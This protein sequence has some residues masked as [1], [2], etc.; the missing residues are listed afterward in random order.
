M[1]EKVIKKQGE[2]ERF[3]K[4]KITVSAVKAGAPL[5]KAR[6]IAD[7]VEKEIEGKIESKVLREKILDKLEAE[8]PEWRKNWETYDKAVKKI[9]NR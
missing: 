2:E 1:V 8:N 3:V 4:E 9:Y 5:E 7:E 6:S